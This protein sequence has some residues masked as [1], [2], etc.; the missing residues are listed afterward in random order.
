[1]K[2]IPILQVNPL[3]LT[4]SQTE[5]M[6]CASYALPASECITGSKLRAIPGSVCATC[7]AMKGRALFGVV[8]SSRKK[9]FDALPTT[10]TGWLAWADSMVTTIE[11][12][13]GDTGFFRWFDS[14][15]LQSVDMLYAIIVIARKMPETKFWLPTHERTIVNE[16]FRR[17]ERDT[18]DG[19]DP[20]EWYRFP[21]N[22]TVRVSGAMI[23]GDVPTTR[24]GLTSTVYDDDGRAHGHA[25]PCGIDR[26]TCGDCRACWDSG[27]ANVSYKLH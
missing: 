26:K 10:V 8:K 27:I 14:G 16:W 21:D 17:D 9:R 25:C 12:K 15:D 18:N 11:K 24:H 22:L 23:N 1:M 4:L 3:G 6:P 5:K 7:Y 2:V 20:S 13:Q 19:I